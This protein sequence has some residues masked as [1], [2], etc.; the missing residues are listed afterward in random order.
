MIEA[1]IFADEVSTNFDEAVRL[2]VEAGATAIELRGG[3]W[4]RNVQNCTDEDVERMKEVLAK[5]GARIGVI[6]S[7]VGK[8]DLENEEEYQTHLRW[9]DRMC[10]LAHEFHTSIIRG[11]AFWNPN[12]PEHIRPNL[13]NYL[14]RIVEKLTPIVRKAE[15]GNV[16]YCL[17]TENS[18]M[19]GTC[20]EIARLIEALEGSPH[21]GVVWDVNNSWHGGELPYP[22]GYS[23]IR[24]RVRH[25][26]VKPNA[27]QNLDTVADTSFSYA[28]ILRI[29]KADGYD[30]CLSI[31]HWGSPHLM[32]EGV[33]QLVALLAHVNREQNK[34]R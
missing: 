32:L 15:Q 20:A 22:D 4:G 31:E 2:S 16:F 21:L 6:G 7:P 18:T 17:E 25:V 8:C 12:R 24:G 14:P 10:E 33:R 13:E 28:D 9:F 27:A 19:T 29:L 1:C 5:Y 23:R 11:F 26:H 30:G 3:I 34:V